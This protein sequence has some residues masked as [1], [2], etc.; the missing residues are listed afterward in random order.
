[1][2]EL[3]EVVGVRVAGERAVEAVDPAVVR[4]GQPPSG[5]AGRLEHER[6][7]AV[8]AGVVEGA[9][10]AVVLAHEHDR[11][12]DRR[13]DAAKSPG[14]GQLV[15]VGD[16][17][18]RAPEDV[19]ALQVIHGRIAVAPAGTNGSTG[20]PSGYCV[21]AASSPGLARIASIADVCTTPP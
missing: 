5:V 9:H 15:S 6:R 10:R 8:L 14:L 12:D 13:R 1:M 4:A 20:N 2:V 3:V 21:R 11:A 7:A 17:Q 19:L 18:P 16:E